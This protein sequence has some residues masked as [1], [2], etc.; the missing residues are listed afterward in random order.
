[1]NVLVGI[2]DFGDNNR[3]SIN[4]LS[5]NGVCFYLWICWCNSFVKFK[6]YNIK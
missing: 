3:L 5:D 1:M 2:D 4:S 6:L